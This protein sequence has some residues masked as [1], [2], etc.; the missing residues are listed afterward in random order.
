MEVS[1][2]ACG[3]SRVPSTKKGPGSYLKKRKMLS[4][5]WKE[6]WNLLSRKARALWESQTFGNLPKALRAVPSNSYTMGATP[7]SHVYNSTFLSGPI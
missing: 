4:L 3:S 6:L 1:I 7:M 2:H 5:T